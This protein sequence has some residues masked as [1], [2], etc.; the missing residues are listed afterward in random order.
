MIL[1][2]AE[3]ARV[4]LSKVAE[5]LLAEAHPVGRT[6]AEFFMSLGFSA[7]RPEELR[8]ALQKLAGGSEVVDRE[9]T[10]F[11][12]KYVVDGLIEGEHRARFVRTVWFVQPG[13][14]VPRLVTAYP[15][16]QRSK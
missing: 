6:K 13:D 4:D 10:I 1:P 5:Y 14:D 8:R 11:G 12:T 9:V 2:N 16:P 3:N 7:T 15:A